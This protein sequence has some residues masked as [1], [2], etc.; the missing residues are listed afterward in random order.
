MKIEFTKSEL[1]ILKGS[2]RNTQ[3]ALETSINWFNNREERLFSLTEME[4]KQR[5]KEIIKLTEVDEVIEK[6]NRVHT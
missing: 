2:L 4:D 6:L 5:K 3:R 1:L